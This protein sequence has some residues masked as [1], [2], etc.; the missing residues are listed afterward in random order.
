MANHGNLYGPSFTFLGIPA[1]DLEIE[2]SYSDADVVIVGA[3]V[4]GGTSHRSGT[5]FGPMAIRAGDYL[6][7]D[8]SRPH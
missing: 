7:H 3:P 2:K 4:D 1:C 5:K 6:P 8:G